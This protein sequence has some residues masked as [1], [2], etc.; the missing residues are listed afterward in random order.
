MT[1]KKCAS[2][3]SAL[4]RY[5]GE[6]IL[7]VLMVAVVWF[8]VET[9]GAQ[10]AG[11]SPTNTPEATV[12]EQQPNP[13]SPQNQD[14]TKEGEQQP[15]SIA[16]TSPSPSQ[17]PSSTP[18]VP[19]NGVY[20]LGEKDKAPAERTGAGMGDILVVRVANLD[21]LLNDAKCKNVDGTDK[22]GC[23]AQ[24]ILL[25][26]DGRPI[27]GLEPESGA[28]NPTDGTLEFHLERTPESDEAW[29]DLLGAPPIFSGK[30]FHRE[31]KVSV[32][33][34]DGRPI[35]SAV[36][37]FQFIRVHE[38]LFWPALAGLLILLTAMIVLA[39]KTNLVRDDVQPVGENR[40]GK[41]TGFAPYSLGRVQMAFWF[42][43]I[44]AS[45]LFVF[46]ITWQLDTVTEQ[47]L[48]LM[49]ISA[50]TALGAVVVDAN[51]SN[52][53]EE[54]KTEDAAT[55]FNQLRARRTELQSRTEALKERINAGPLDA[56]EASELT[57]ANVEL[58]KVKKEIG[59]VSTVSRSFLDDLLTDARGYSFH[60]FQIFVWTIVLGIIFLHGVYNRLAMPLFSATL[61]ALLG[62]SGATYLGFKIPEQQETESA[63]DGST[64]PTR[65]PTEDLPDPPEQL[66]AE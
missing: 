65:S 52:N 18:H 30:L 58:K 47:A 4:S 10:S 43:L 66:P 63:G 62:I 26:L 23:E 55:K 6:G 19:K 13:S 60:R 37:N 1:M 34:E 27:K 20:G 39:R 25:Y 8:Q 35:E 50:A 2:A 14:T 42:F 41:E 15:K 54:S 21:K 36:T 3:Q 28:P 11:T 17:S 12:K 40:K 64:E 53:D 24:K 59:D 29:A 45:F 44:L 7:L 33:L 5:F 56:E 22:A 61:L 48:A 46:I 31:M 38:R 51:K 16:S 32:G 9:V 49:G 57:I